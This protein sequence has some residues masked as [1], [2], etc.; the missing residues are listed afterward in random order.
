MVE[1]EGESLPKLALPPMDQT[2]KEKVEP[3]PV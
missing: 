1:G 3:S 2:S